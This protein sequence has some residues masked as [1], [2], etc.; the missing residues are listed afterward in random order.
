MRLLIGNTINKLRKTKGFR[1]YFV[2]S[3]MAVSRPTYAGWEKDRGCPSFI[4]IYELVQLYNISM[5]EF[6]YMLEEDNKPDQNR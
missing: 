4:Q 5:E 6:T 1:Q 3:R 2:A